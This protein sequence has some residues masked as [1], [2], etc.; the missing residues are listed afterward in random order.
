M[1]FVV[2]LQVQSKK[3]VPSRKLLKIT[4]QQTKTTEKLDAESQESQ[5]GYPKK[6]T[7]KHQ[8]IT[9]HCLRERL[10]VRLKQFQKA[11]NPLRK[12]VDAAVRYHQG[13]VVRC[14]PPVAV[15]VQLWR[16]TRTRTTTT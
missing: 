16:I 14:L 9:N 11:A 15:A 4:S 12:T 8:Q 6:P 1:H 3:L 2:T 7:A 10:L 5:I 13:S